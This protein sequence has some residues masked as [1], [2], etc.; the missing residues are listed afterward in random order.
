VHGAATRNRT[1]LRSGWSRLASQ[2][3]PREGARSASGGVGP[4]KE[5]PHSVYRRNWP[6]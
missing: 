6:P 4:P 1:Q 3:S 5:H 2:R